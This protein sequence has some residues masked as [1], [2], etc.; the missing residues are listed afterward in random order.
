LVARRHTS[1]VRNAPRLTFVA[2]PSFDQA[3]HIAQVLRAPAVARDLA[4]PAERE[5]RD[6][7]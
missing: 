4:D 7:G 1:P 5:N 6:D 3:E 2:D